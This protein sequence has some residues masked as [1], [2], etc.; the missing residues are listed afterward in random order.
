MKIK[1]D[2]RVESAYSDLLYWLKELEKV[3]RQ[4]EQGLMI[5][6]ELKL[7]FTNAVGV[8]KQEISNCRQLASG[9]CAE[10]T[11][12]PKKEVQARA[13]NSKYVDWL[14]NRIDWMQ[15]LLDKIE[16]LKQTCFPKNVQKSEEN[17]QESEDDSDLV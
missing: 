4:S 8:I 6:N 3:D 12:T 2:D 15:R 9:T 5:V 16:V 11:H 10:I 1:K 13:Q 17:V 14:N 7:A